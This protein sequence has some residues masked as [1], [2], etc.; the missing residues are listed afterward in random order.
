MLDQILSTKTRELIETKQLL[1]LP[2]LLDQLPDSPPPSFQAAITR[3]QLNIIAEIKYASPSHGSF[4][5]H[6][7]PGEIAEIYAQNGA[8]AIS[9]LTE[10]E[11]FSGDPEH[12]KT[13]RQ[14]LPGMPLLRKDFLID[15][16]QVPESRFY[17]ASAYLVIVAALDRHGLRGLIAAGQEYGLD[18]LVE[19]HD[20]YELEAA[21]QSGAEII[22]VNNRNLRAF[23]IDIDIS[24]DIARRLEHTPGLTLISESG[25]RE[26]SLILELRDAGFDAFLVGTLLMES[27]DP[28]AK[29]KELAGLKPQASSLKP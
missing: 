13:V 10:K 24:F 22:G 5:N 15:A 27:P 17:G 18:A 9:V 16:Y 6:R 23:E 26:S 20:P 28:G 8:A 12:L 2:R 11:Y 21:L 7:P 1:P 29:L 25:L 3:D 19:V 14:K 4:D